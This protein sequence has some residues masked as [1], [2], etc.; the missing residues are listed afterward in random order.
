MLPS[1]RRA[2][3]QPETF[4]AETT[5]LIHI[6]SRTETQAARRGGVSTDRHREGFV[7]TVTAVRHPD[8]MR[9]GGIACGQRRAHRRVAIL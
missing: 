7:R 9:R 8:L 4:A 3:T 1:M 5:A 6:P 2:H